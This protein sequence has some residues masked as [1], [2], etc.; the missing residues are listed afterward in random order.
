MSRVPVLVSL[1]QNEGNIAT[2]ALYHTSGSGPMLHGK[3]S[4][5]KWE[6]LTGDWLQWAP[7][8]FLGR[9][10]EF[11]TDADREA[12]TDLANFYF[13]ADTDM[14]Q[15]ERTHDN[16]RIMGCIYGMAFFYLGADMD[17]KLL[18]G[19]GLEVYN[20]MLCHPPEV[21]LMYIQRLTPLQ[22]LYEVELFNFNIDTLINIGYG[23]REIKGQLSIVVNK[24]SPFEIRPQSFTVSMSNLKTPILGFHVAVLRQ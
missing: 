16:L 12:V 6:L 4:S 21:S 20:M 1:C 11:I 5:K 3:C 9:E 19:A 2:A 22:I 14:A 13:G 18:A 15:L 7:L 24:L 8:L 23:D 17:S 10:R